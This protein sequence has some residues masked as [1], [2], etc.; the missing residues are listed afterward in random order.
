MKCFT[1]LLALLC[2]LPVCA[3]QERSSGPTAGQM[4]EIIRAE[5][6]LRF[7]ET[8]KSLL[9]NSDPQT[10]V[11]SVLAAGRIGD[12][13]AL[14]ML[15]QMLSKDV[16][17]VA[18]MAAFAIGEIES[19][20][21]AGVILEVLRDQTKDRTVRTS[22]VEAAGKI[23]AANPKADEAKN[24]G[25]AILDVLE[26][27]FRRG[28]RLDPN[29]T[30]LAITA[31][32]RSKPDDGDYVLSKFLTNTGPRI[33]AD[34]ANALARLGS[35]RFNKKLQAMVLTDEEPTARAN[36]ARGLGAA[37][38]KSASNLLLEAAF[39]D[40][41]QRV[42]YSAIGALG[43][44][45]ERATGNRLVE[46]AEELH[47][48]VQKAGEKADYVNELL[49]ISSALGTVMEGTEDARTVSFLDKFGKSLDHRAMEVEMALVRVSPKA[50]G[51]R[52][53][54]E[55]ADWRASRAMAAAIGKL[56]DLK[57]SEIAERS[58]TA[59]ENQLR[60][61]LGSVIEGKRRPDM[62][63][64][65]ILE[66]FSLYKTNDLSKVLRESLKLEDV[67]IRE[68][69]A[70]LLGEQE[71]SARSA[72]FL[73]DYVALR[74]ALLK[75]ESD[76]LNDAALASLEAIKKK[77]LK[78]KGQ[79][80]VR[81]DPIDPVRR[82]LNSPD[83]LIRRR[84]RSILREVG[85]SVGV[86]PDR[87]E[88]KNSGN[89]RL[90]R[91]DYRSAV[92]RAKSKA[93]LTTRK[94]TFTIEFFPEAAPLTVENF[95]YLAKSGYYNGLEI[96]RVVPNFVVQDGDPRGDGSGGPGWHI[97]CEIN[98]MGYERGTVGMALSGKDTGGSQWFVAHSP[99]PH[100]D[101]GYTVFGKVN[102]KDMAVVDILARGDI[103]E[104]VEIFE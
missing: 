98:Q 70:R 79:D 34:T 48:L 52:K 12:A 88:F 40:E 75:S 27:E 4:L 55:S 68:A 21:A 100:L 90:R 76:K 69:A 103:I 67:V 13:S 62:S 25:E 7:D 46:R 47:K 74:D 32:I 77:H 50:Y 2:A 57:G 22:S 53:L 104:R 11:R 84:A 61:Y 44:I 83:Y 37:G 26:F 1:I 101:G 16:P 58:K 78:L 59:G 35:K 38:D 3:L 18:Q 45:A 6:E 19:V 87:V 20:K 71:M 39:T 23:A 54:L 65:A 99:Q 91:A 5:D 51:G 56:A 92:E 94:G 63:Y 41:D 102:E 14:P 96:H 15:S 24:L 17:M 64:P 72:T 80:Y 28:S 85:I 42:R 95:I 30:L 9:K 49:L 36:A 33:R 97:R 43:R 60:R 31:V 73:D 93:V 10:R 86:S 29:V 81:I 82:A 89:T 66:A 8:L